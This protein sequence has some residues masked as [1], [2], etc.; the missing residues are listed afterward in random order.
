MIDRAAPI[1]ATNKEGVQKALDRFDR[2]R[3]ADGSD[4]PPVCGSDARTMQTTPPSSTPDKAR[5]REEKMKSIAAKLNDLKVTDR[6]LIW[7]SDL[8]GAAGGDQPLMPPFRHRR[9]G[10]QGNPRPCPQGGD[11]SSWMAQALAHGW[12]ATMLNWLIGPFVLGPSD[13]GRA[14]RAIG[15]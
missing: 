12:K 8:M 4:G 15:Y 2:I 3:N 10:A 14:G 11:G 13:H 5:R 7:N 6:S 1:P 9:R